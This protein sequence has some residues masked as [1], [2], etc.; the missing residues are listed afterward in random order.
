MVIMSQIA[1]PCFTLPRVTLLLCVLWIGVFEIRFYLERVSLQLKSTNFCGFCQPLIVGGL[2][3]LDFSIDDGETLLQ[4]FTAAT[5]RVNGDVFAQ[6]SGIH[7]GAQLEPG[8]TLNSYWTSTMNI[9]TLFIWLKTPQATEQIAYTSSVL[10][11]FFLERSM[12]RREKRK[13]LDTNI[14]IF[15]DQSMIT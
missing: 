13:R 8:D 9:S 14:F 4:Q 10:S 15:L 3:W 11:L 12:R 7:L 5:P 1:M 6:V 2:C